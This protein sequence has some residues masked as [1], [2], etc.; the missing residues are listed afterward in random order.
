MKYRARIQGIENLQ[1]RAKKEHW[2][3]CVSKIIQMDQ[4]LFG[5]LSLPRLSTEPKARR[6]LKQIFDQ[7]VWSRRLLGLI[8]FS[9]WS[10]IELRRSRRQ[11][12][13]SWL[14]LARPE[15]CPCRVAERV[16]SRHSRWSSL[17]GPRFEARKIRKSFFFPS[18]CFRVKWKL[19]LNDQTNDYEAI[20]NCV[21]KIQKKT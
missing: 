10:L 3:I 8:F 21:I 1:P 7:R 19:L 9:S 18:V 5:P 20:L 15:M 4:R 13:M 2:S 12:K 6:H 16:K 11:T 14:V 17:Q